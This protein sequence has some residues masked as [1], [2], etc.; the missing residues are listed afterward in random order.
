MDQEAIVKLSAIEKDVDEVK[1]S[2][3]GMRITNDD[4][5]K[6]A[7]NFVATIKDKLNRI[8]HWRKFFVKPLND[9]VKKVNNMFRM[10]S[11]PLKD[12][13]S[14]VKKVI[15][16]YIKA[17]EEVRMQEYQQKRKEEEE[18]KRKI[19]EA[20]KN[21]K[22]KSEVRRLEEME[23]SISP[24]E[25]EQAPQ[26]VRAENGMI[27]IKKVWDFEIEDV[28]KIPLEFLK[29]DETAI[30]KAISRGDRDI[31]GVKIFQKNQVAVR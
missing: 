19:E 4:E 29:V 31:S 1:Q 17:Q 27:S 8:E 25:V 21:A 5:L 22:S 26:R 14:N 9:Q 10:Q 12:I 23:K 24:V 18:K 2:F 28:S 11:D 7:T 13:E 3:N 30:R 16:M 6:S 20:K 15:S